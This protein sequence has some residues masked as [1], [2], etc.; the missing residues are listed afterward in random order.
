MSQNIPIISIGILSIR[1]ENLPY[2]KQKGVLQKSYKVMS[3]ATPLR[4][5][6]V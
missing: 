1:I 4:V 6:F 3:F 5:S 2:H